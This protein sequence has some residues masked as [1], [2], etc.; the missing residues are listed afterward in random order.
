MK[1]MLIALAFLVSFV[2]NAQDLNEVRKKYPLAQDNK[3]IAQELNDKF[4]QVESSNPTINAYKGAVLT[5]IADFEKKK[6]EKLRLFK[7]GKKLLDDAIQ[8]NAA[9]IEMRMIRLGV[10]ENTPKILGY[11]KEMNEDKEFILRNYQATTSK[12]EKDVVKKFALQSNS[13]SDE[14]KEVFD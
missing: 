1:N 10:Q 2:G 14:E 6:V 11:H 7:E 4:E 8:T 13:F 5:L 12:A 3:E 9:N